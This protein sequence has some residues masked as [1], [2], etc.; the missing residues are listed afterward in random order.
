M[1]SLDLRTQTMCDVTEELVLLCHCGRI[2]NT[3]RDLTSALP[4][5]SCFCTCLNST[6]F[7]FFLLF[8]FPSEDLTRPD[9]CVRCHPPAWTVSVCVGHPELSPVSS[10]YANCGT[11]GTDSRPAFPLRPGC[12][13]L[14]VFFQA[15]CLHFKRCCCI[16][17]S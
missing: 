10:Y 9:R 6:I 7:F 8:F 14:F 4:L 5:L 2:S 1:F 3:C 13:S 16:I 12:S 11:A 15:L 17:H